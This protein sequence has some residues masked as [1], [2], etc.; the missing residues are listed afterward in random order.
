[1][2]KSDIPYSFPGEKTLDIVSI[3]KDPRFDRIE[4]RS[5]GEEAENIAARIVTNW[6]GV[7]D[8]TEISVLNGGVL[9]RDNFYSRHLLRLYP[10]SGARASAI[11]NALE[12]KQ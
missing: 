3:L 10:F 12:R 2:G 6:N 5:Y 11:M 1:M 4:G 7:K 9:N 8:G